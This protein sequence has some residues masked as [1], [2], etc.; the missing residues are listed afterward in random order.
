MSE[1]KELMS[2][3]D[4]CL[5]ICKSIW[6]CKN[7]EQK[8]GCYN[9]LETYIKKHGEDNVGITFIEI[10]LARLETLIKKMEERNK[11]LQELT[12]Q[13]QKELEAEANKNPQIAKD[14]KE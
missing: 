14:K 12:E 2:A 10:E 6:S 13:R 11:K 4:E 3:K 9:M 5:A 7:A 1:I 8:E